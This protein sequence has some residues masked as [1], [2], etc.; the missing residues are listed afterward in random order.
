MGVLR[1]IRLKLLVSILRLLA[2]FGAGKPKASPDHVAFLPS[3][4][5]GRQI[6][7]NV[8]NPAGASFTDD[9][10]A[11]PCPVL[12]NLHGSGFIMPAHGSDDEFCARVAKETEYMVLDIQYRLAP[13][14][15]FPSALHDVEDA[16]NYVLQRPA[17]FDLSR[18]SISGFS[19]GGNLALATSGVVFPAST[20]NNAIL[21]YPSTDKSKDP[22]DRVVPDPSAGNT[23]PVAVSRFFDDCYISP[24]VDRRNPLVSPS[25]APTDRFPGRVLFVT[26]ARDNLC[27]EAEELAT[28]MD[29]EG[30]RVTI[31]RMEQCGHGWD[32]F[33]KPG[34]VQAEAKERAYAL[35][36]KML[37]A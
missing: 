12:L 13:E 32:K 22:K 34:T 26:A 21:L 23:V 28:R 1:Y 37:Q 18:F 5:R 27:F 17:R 24:T 20:F 30:R 8:Y 29:V 16:V 6:K 33:A 3:R 4:N 11:K 31:E 10:A 2:R 15:P 19:A 36:V 9:S 35:A 25:F 14:C 7:A